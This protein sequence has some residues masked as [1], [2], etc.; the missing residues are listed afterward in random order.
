MYFEYFRSKGWLE[1][2]QPTEIQGL[3]DFVPYALQGVQVSGLYYA[4][5]QLGCANLMF[6]QRSDSAL[7]QANTLT[8]VNNALSRCTYTSTIPPDYR[9]L[10]VDMSGGTTTATLYLDSEHS[11]TGQYPLPLPWSP[12]QLD[13]AA[14]G[15]LRSLLAMASYENGTA[16][17][18]DPYQ[19]SNW[20]SSGWGRAVVGYSESMS[21]M[22]DQ[23]LSTV[24]FKVMPL[25]D[26]ANPPLF[27][28]DVIGI[29]TSTNQ[30]GTRSLAVQLANVMASRL[31]M[32]AS[33]GPDASNPRPQYLMPTRT[34]IFQTLGQS[35]PLYTVMYGLVTDSNPVMFKLDSQARSWLTAMKGTIQAESRANYPCSCDYPSQT[36]IPSDSQAPA[37]CQQTCA[38]HGGWNGQWT[39]TYPAAPQGQSACGCKTCPVQ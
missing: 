33:I 6:Y 31:T 18:S 13:P 7:A 36:Y 39:N 1:P 24:A 8:Q 38:A 16:S 12:S 19:R 17:P 35:F 23:T 26:N 32:V 27:Y 34:S 22:S 21:D 15:N 20:F 3:S 29:N 30:R 28:A 9:G 5:P 37:I 4:I 14:I 25:S 2:L 10:M 11:I